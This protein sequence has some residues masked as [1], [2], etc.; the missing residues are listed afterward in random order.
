VTP[1]C[2]D[3]ERGAVHG[4]Q[5]GPPAGTAGNPPV[6]FEVSNFKLG[7]NPPYPEFEVRG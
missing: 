4:E 7:V 6:L 5:V 1:R 2:L 3:G